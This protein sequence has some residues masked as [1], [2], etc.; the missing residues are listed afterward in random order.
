[1]HTQCGIKGKKVCCA[2]VQH[3]LLIRA[4]NS[5]IIDIYGSG[6][7]TTIPFSKH[8]RLNASDLSD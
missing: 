4:V 1:M 7:N 6:L 5:V 2:K 3:Q 8:K